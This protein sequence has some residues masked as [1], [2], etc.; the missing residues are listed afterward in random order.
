MFTFWKSFYTNWSHIVFEYECGETRACRLETK[1]RR[2]K[3]N[4]LRYN[5]KMRACVRVAW[6]SGLHER[7]CRCDSKKCVK[8]KNYKPFLIINY[9]DFAVVLQ[10]SHRTL[11]SQIWRVRI[12][13]Y[14]VR[15]S[16]KRVSLLPPPPSFLP[17]AFLCIFY[18]P[19]TST[20]YNIQYS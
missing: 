14:N 7:R 18:T 16:R 1:K 20:M 2:N 10:Y 19:R 17:H 11:T 9:T 3:I 15:L 8:R 6:S 4:S 12:I 5:K 13:R